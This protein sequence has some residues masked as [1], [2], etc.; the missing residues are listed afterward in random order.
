M[1]SF[2]HYA[3]GAIGDWMYRVMAG[4][5]IDEAAPGYKHIVIQPQP[6][7]GFTSVKASHK[8]LYGEVASAWTRDGSTFTLTTDVPA[9]HPRDD[10][11]A[12]REERRGDA[13][14]QAARQRQW[15]HGRQAG[16]PG[17]DRRGRIGALRVQLRDADVG[18][19][20]R[21][22][23]LRYRDWRTPLCSAGLQACHKLNRHEERR[24]AAAA[25]AVPLEGRRSRPP[26]GRGSPRLPL[27]QAGRRPH[28]HEHRRRQH[29]VETDG[30]GSAD[31]RR[32]RGA[33][34]EGIGR[35][36]ADREARRV[37]VAVPRQGARDAAAVRGRSPIAG[38]R[39]RSKTRCTRCTATASST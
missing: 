22:E 37:R 29:V 12:G 34:G 3:Y 25:R 5:D 1:N 19:K 8:S 2:N 7:G 27:E 10:P 15:R 21:A 26:E 14:R 20:L 28:A 38:P 24:R 13:R 11:P 30:D 4:I 32:G 36:S 35:R 9:K 39:R 23:A 16:R 18:R 33:V 17:R 6:G 31:G